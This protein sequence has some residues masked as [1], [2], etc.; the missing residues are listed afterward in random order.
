MTLSKD[1]HH[2]AER[3]GTEDDKK[4]LLAAAEMA[5][6]LAE[7]ESFDDWITQ[8]RKNFMRCDL[9]ADGFLDRDEFRQLCCTAFELSPEQAEAA[10][11]KWDIDQGKTVG[12][13]EFSALMS[14]WHVELAYHTR[15]QKTEA[16]IKRNLDHPCSWTSPYALPFGFMCSLCT[17][18][19][20]WLPYC[21]TAKGCMNMDDDDPE[22][23]ARKDKKCQ[24]VALHSTKG[25]IMEGPPED[26]L[27]PDHCVRDPTS[28][29]QVE[30]T[31]LVE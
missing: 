19:L 1:L 3:S 31:P 5:K 17:L 18:G 28:Q 11:T 7:K 8:D 26:I 23:K 20:S 29:L 9:N 12:P 10:F 27:H 22:L 14:I 30:A 6:D 16:L 2:T 13:V 15:R 25:K 21:F 4:E 24:E